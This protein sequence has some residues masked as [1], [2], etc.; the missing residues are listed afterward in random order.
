MTV[1][2]ILLGGAPAY[3]SLAMDA[4]AAITRRDVDTEI[5]NLNAP[6]ITSISDLRD[7]VRDLTG[8]VHEL[9]KVKRE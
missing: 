3:V 8:E 2:G 4:H 6:I 5:S 9:R 1:I 7:E